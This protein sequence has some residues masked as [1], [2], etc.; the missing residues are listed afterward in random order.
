MRGPEFLDQAR[1]VKFQTDMADYINLADLRGLRITLPPARDQR[2]IAEVLG[3]L[4][5]KIESNRRRADVAESIL[6]VLAASWNGVPGVPLGELAVPERETCAPADV[7]GTP[8]DHYSLP[9]FDATRL[10]ERTRGDTI[11]SNKLVLK[12]ERVL[13]SR[14]NPAT[15]RTWFAVP[16]PGVL[17]AAS[18]EFLVLRPA[19]GSGAGP[20][21]LAVRDELFRSELSRRATGTS[22]SHQRVR[23]DDVLSIEV[24]DVR[25]LEQEV[26][27]ESESLLRLAHDTRVESRTLAEIR[28]VL[29][30]ELLSGCLR[31]PMAKEV[32]DAAT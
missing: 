29:L 17:A 11:K 25:T 1:S 22:G 3:A 20:L 13:V 10:P 31:V 7:G 6:D 27:D 23:P 14:L 2:A 26:V 19:T 28:D 21:W 15:N 24:P 12:G 4:D 18:T 32:A 30:P 5:D 9:A 16:E 8:V